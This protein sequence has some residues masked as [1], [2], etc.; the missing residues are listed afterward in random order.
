MVYFFTYRLSERNHI[1][2]KVHHVA[3]NMT[4]FVR[5]TLYHLCETLSPSFFDRNS[6]LHENLTQIPQNRFAQ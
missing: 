4:S 6:I 1:C 3:V 2:L 5:G